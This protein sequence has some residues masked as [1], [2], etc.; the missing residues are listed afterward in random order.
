MLAP[1]QGW[2]EGGSPTRVLGD[3]GAG[4]Q[5]LSPAYRSRQEDKGKKDKSICL[6]L[7]AKESLGSPISGPIH[8]LAQEGP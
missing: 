3:W 2:V 7:A 4:G 6:C 1:P 8:L 5:A